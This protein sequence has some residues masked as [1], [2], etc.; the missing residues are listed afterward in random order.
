MTEEAQHEAREDDFRGTGE[1]TFGQTSPL[2]LTDN[3]GADHR[4]QVKLQID[5]DSLP[6]DAPDHVAGDINWAITGLNAVVHYPNL[7]LWLRTATRDYLVAHHRAAPHERAGHLRVASFDRQER[8]RA[9]LTEGTEI[10]AGLLTPF[11]A[12]NLMYDVVVKAAYRFLRSD[13]GILLADE[14]YLRL[15]FTGIDHPIVSTLD[16]DAVSW[17]RHHLLKG[18]FP[19]PTARSRTAFPESSYPDVPSYEDPSD[20]HR[21]ALETTKDHVSRY[22]RNTDQ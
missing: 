17:G 4:G 19:R 11:D 12:V 6:D 2:Q 18:S 14:M 13:I 20:E 3:Q 21:H 10:E 1:Y 8:G 15:D 16:D 5:P 22:E 9:P 7:V